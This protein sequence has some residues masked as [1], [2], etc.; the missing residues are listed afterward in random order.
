[1]SLLLRAAAATTTRHLTVT[2]SFMGPK[3]K[4]GGGKGGGGKAVKV[5]PRKASQDYEKL[6]THCCGINVW[7]PDFDF[8]LSDEDKETFFDDPILKPKEEYPERLF[9][10]R[11]LIDLESTELK[12]LDLTKEPEMYWERFEMELKRHE[13]FYYGDK[14]FIEGQLHPPH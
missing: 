11:L 3:K 14:T 10:P 6:A 12:D 4:K 1:M 7:N 5:D 8:G 2:A 9:D 13:K